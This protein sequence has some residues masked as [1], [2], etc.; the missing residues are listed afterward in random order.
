M[1]PSK[2]YSLLLSIGILALVWMVLK[3]TAIPSVK[4][5]SHQIVTKEV[6]DKWMSQLS[7]W[8]R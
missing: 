7:N 5:Q 6:V 8:G 1:R 4:A 3:V 2:Q